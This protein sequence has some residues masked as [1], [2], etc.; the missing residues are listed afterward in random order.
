M[1]K[2]KRVCVTADDIRAGVPRS[3]GCCPV[4]LA[5]HR[6]LTHFEAH[7]I[8]IGRSHANLMTGRWPDPMVLTALLPENARQFIHEFD[9]GGVAQP[10]EFDLVF[11]R[12]KA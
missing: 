12:R 4:A 3:P 7:Q 2:T 8:S 11:K 5:L 9:N 1:S 6:T 10:I